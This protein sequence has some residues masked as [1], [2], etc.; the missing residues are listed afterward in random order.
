MSENLYSW[1]FYF[2][3]LSPYMVYKNRVTIID[4]DGRDLRL[5]MYGNLEWEDDSIL[6]GVDINGKQLFWDKRYNAYYHERPVFE[7]VGGIE[8]VRLETGYVLRSY[9]NLVKPT[10]KQDIYYN[11]KIIWMNNW[12]ITKYGSSKDRDYVPQ[13]ILSFGYNHFYVR[14]DDNDQP[15][16]TIIDKLGN[17]IDRRWTVPDKDN[18]KSPIWQFTML[19]NAYTGKVGF[20]DRR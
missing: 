9:P 3:N 10:K 2:R 17:F 4:M 18:H 13:R 20:P 15:S 1:G 19:T 7:Y 11:H 12:L 6:R 14:T 16:V 8:M 5:S